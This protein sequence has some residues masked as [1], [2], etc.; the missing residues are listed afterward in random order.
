[1]CGI[2]ALYDKDKSGGQRWTKPGPR[3][4]AEEM[5]AT[6]NRRG[7]D[8]RHQAVLGNTLLGH[9]RLSIIDRDTGSQPILSETT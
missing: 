8:E 4:A 9:T 1:M 2:V 6:L 7:P 3:E 5:L